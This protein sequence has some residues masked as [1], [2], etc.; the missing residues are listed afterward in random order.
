MFVT[1]FQCSDIHVHAK[2]VITFGIDKVAI[3]A[4]EFKIDTSL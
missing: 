2:L 4:L 3:S 1:S